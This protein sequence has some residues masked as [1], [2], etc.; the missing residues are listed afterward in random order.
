MSTRNIPTRDGM[1]GK[2]KFCL[3]VE[4]TACGSPYETQQE[5]PFNADQSAGWSQ[6]TTSQE[7]TVARFNPS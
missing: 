3:R 7:S 1:N 4:E 6:P 2:Q 5:I